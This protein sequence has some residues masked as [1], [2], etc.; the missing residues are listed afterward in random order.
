MD[1]SVVKLFG[2]DVVNN[3]FQQMHTHIILK[4]VLNVIV[5]L[6]GDSGLSGKP[7]YM[8]TTPPI[9]LPLNSRV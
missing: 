4:C 1:A 3:V 6:S 8:A 2:C 5:R 9:Q 7:L